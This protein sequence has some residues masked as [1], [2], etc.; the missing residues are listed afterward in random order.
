MLKFLINKPISVV[1]FFLA[2]FILGI[3]A[4]INIPVSLL[5]NID[6]PEITVHVSNPNAS[7]RELENTTVR[8][9]RQQ[10]MQVGRV[11]DIRSE[12]RDGSGVIFLSLEYGVDTDLSF[13]EVN[14][15]VDAAMRFLP[16]NVDRPR[17]VKA[18]A[19]DIPVF[20]LHLTLRDDNCFEQT[21]M[22]RFIELSEF[23]ESVIRRRFE[24][25]PPVA[26]VDLSGLVGRQIII[27]PNPN[28]LAT[29]VIT[30]SD[31]ESALSS[32]NV[33]PGSMTVRDGHY[34]Y[35]IRFSS[36]LRTI[37]DIQNIFIRKHG[38]IH[39]LRDLAEIT[40]APERE[41][42]MAIY[43]GKR[44]IV[45]SVIKRSEEDISTMRRAMSEEVERFRRDFPEIEFHVT[46]NQSELL[47][48]T[49]TN[50]QRNLFL[51]FIFVLLVSI[52]FLKDW[53]LGAIVGVILFVSLVI[54]LLF[55]FLF[56]ITFNVVSLTGLILALGNMID[57]SIVAADNIT[58]YRKRGL[59]IPDACVAG[60]NEV[61]T[62]MLSSML[63]S[64]AIF[65]PLIFMSGIAGALFFDQAFSVTVGLA[66]SYL[67]GITLLPVLYKLLYSTKTGKRHEVCNEPDLAPRT[68][69]HA[70]EKP[71]LAE[72]MYDAGFKW[73]FSH[74]QMTGIICLA[75]A[76]SGIWFFATIP[77]TM[78][79][80]LSQNELL[81]TI[82]W[83][84]NIHIQENHE[85]SL[86]LS[87]MLSDISEEHAA[88]VG[89]QQFALNREREQ[90]TTETQFYVRVKTSA[91][92][93]PLQ[94]KVLAY[95]SE[96]YPQA[97]V[98][99]SP[100][101]TIFERIFSTGDAELVVEFYPI[102]RN[103]EVEPHTIRALEHHI[104]ILTEESIVGSAFQKQLNLS[105]NRE[106][107]LLYNIPH[108][109]IHNALRTAFRDNRI[110]T[111]RSQR[112]MPVM[113]GGVEKSVRDVLEQTLI[114]TSTN[115]DGSR[116][117]MA[118]SLFVRASTSEDLKIITAGR[119]GEYIPIFFY[120]LRDTERVIEQIR[121]DMAR[122]R[123]W[124]VNFSG[125]FFTNQRMLD[126]MMVILLVSILLMFFILSAQ[127]GNFKQPL[128]ILLEIPIN[129]GFMLGVLLI[130]GHSLNLMSAIG[131]VVASG[132]I[133][134]DSILKVDIMN[135]LRK[136]GFSLMDAI[137]EG[138]RRRLKA[139]V[140]TSFTTIVCMAPLVFSQDLGSQLEAPLAV[141]LIAGM[142]IGTPISLFVVPL[143]YWI[144]YRNKS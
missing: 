108:A 70:P 20:N 100:T 30:L 67:T 49:M 88:L 79:P 12:T 9:L 114:E 103:R 10:L 48:Y 41:T 113:F 139:I 59:T 112:Y 11:R 138:G 96:R 109:Q 120:H 110:A 115:A 34:E 44:A 36:V 69:H 80:D 13:I 4:Y 78:M 101:G 2:M 60:V 7:A 18:S 22:Q 122:N 25:L 92:V 123:D 14:E 47:D 77:K 144:I 1:M 8:P 105:V 131:L 83:N 26:M 98:T 121:A 57:N 84:E 35:V 140:M 24:Q 21:D 85:R 65:L 50:L 99:F 3:V 97:L 53:R 90:T 128:I 31:I 135:V 132:I 130:T 126:E 43:N 87:R 37:E 61:S 117:M 40:L 134:N 17:V 124:N 54:S 28:L 64:V 19:T 107:L 63:T 42:G 91:D 142:I 129:I 55:F 116:N 6:I 133:I 62:P 143:F 68:T 82:D 27:T 104:A 111:L 127:F 5:P 75:I 137:H 94:D 125:M 23:A 95:F 81:I 106:K 15:R 56:G 72:R 118:L 102:D 52:L 39:Q 76:L 66:V 86:R 45:L 33:E 16:R 29:G 46:Q 93:A 141:A 38:R 73:V 32:N 51:A 74:K 119:A 58:Q 136:E 89:E 71:S